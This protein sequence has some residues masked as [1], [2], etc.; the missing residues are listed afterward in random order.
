ML[1]N[2]KYMTGSVAFKI[3]AALLGLGAM[4]AALIF[5]SAAAFNNVRSQFDVMVGEHVPDLHSGSEI[6]G[7]SGGLKDALSGM[8]LAANPEEL[9][10]STVSFE[11]ELTE[12]RAAVKSLRAEETALLLP[13]LENAEAGL[14]DLARLRGKEFQNQKTMLEFSTELRKLSAEISLILTGLMDEA[15]FELTLGNEDAIA[16]I[17]GTLSGLVEHDFALLQNVLSLRGEVY[18]MAVSLVALGETDDPGVRSIMA[19]LFEGAASRAESGLQRSLEVG[20]GASYGEELTAA[21]EFFQAVDLSRAR[22]SASTLREAL[23]FRQVSDSALSGAIDDITFELVIKVSD[24]TDS[25][26]ETLYGLVENQLEQIREVAALDRVVQGF[27]IT[28]LEGMIAA[29]QT[30]LNAVEARLVLDRAKLGAYLTHPITEGFVAKLE[31]LLVLVEPGTGITGMRQIMLDNQIEA[32]DISRDAA[33]A[34]LEIAQV[35]TGQGAQAI[36][37]INI[38]G[39]SISTQIDAAKS[40]MNMISIASVALVLVVMLIVFVSIVRPLN[41]LA[42]ATQ[43]LSNED[44][45]ELP[46]FGKI[47]GEIGAVA[48]ALAVFRQNIIDNKKMQQEE[49][50]RKEAERAAEKA[51]DQQKQAEKERAREEEAEQ[52]QRKQA[53]IAKDEAEKAALRDKANAERQKTEEEQNQVVASLASGLESLASGDLTV[54]LDTEFPESYE[55]LRADFNA[56]LVSLEGAL[57]RISGSGQTIHENTTEISGGAT[58]LSRRTEASAATLEETAVALTEITTSVQ[59]A[60]EGA[61]KANEVV[62]GVRGEAENSETVV[63]EATQAMSEIEASSKE[64]AKIIDVIDDIAFQTNLLALNAGVE[65]ARAGESGRG[66]AVVA[67]E[68]RSLAQRSS[69]AAKEISALI[70]ESTN[71]VKKGV[72]LVDQTGSALHQIVAGIA[73]VSEHVSDIASAAVEQANGISEVNK[74]VAQ[75]DKATQMNAAMFEETSAASLS[76]NTEA[77]DLTRL[78]RGFVIGEN[79]GED[80]AEVEKWE[81]DASTETSLQDTA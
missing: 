49:L 14:R 6:I 40:Q 27:M 1:Q 37:K 4:M 63:Q 31:Q 80:E 58:D 12:A 2:I 74:A 56:A 25:N 13:L 8:L 3:G 43:Q 17:D 73:G 77:S 59:V 57:G 60:A 16:T 53:A 39:A 68:V 51:A 81:T 78:L 44:L 55:R 69:D 32:I 61:S 52:A 35:A 9:Q 30:I 42:R 24:A 11:T 45:S 15:V 21:L 48:K 76:L 64:I 28:A 41:R 54:R 29:D 36:D 75:L 67:T 10:N 20:L 38:A 71:Q 66:F 26:K 65:A 33:E 50:S 19:D 7:Y 79:N 5:V 70:S 47:G 23:S 62:R 18:L 34:V 46:K 72:G 22:Q